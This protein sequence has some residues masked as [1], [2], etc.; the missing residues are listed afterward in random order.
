MWILFFL[1]TM[2]KMEGASLQSMLRLGKPTDLYYYSDAD[3]KKQSIPTDQN[4]QFFL[5]LASLT[6][7]QSQFVFSPNQGLAHI[8]FG[9]KLPEQGVNSADY[10]NLALENSWL[11]S[12]IEKFSYRI[13]G[14]VQYFLTGAQIRIINL[15][16]A[17]NPTSKQDLFNLGG[18]SLSALAD[19]A[20]DNLYAYCYL[21][22]PF[23]S[24]NA[25]VQR[26][27]P[28]PTELLNSSVILTLNLRPLSQIFSSSAAGGSLAGVPTALSDGYVQ[29]QQI[30]AQQSSDLM[31]KTSDRSK[32]YSY[33]ASAWYNQELEIPI[34]AQSGSQEINLVGFQ[35]GQLR[36]I[37]MW[38]TANEDTAP[39]TT[40]P[41][42]RQNTVFALPRDVQLI[43]NGN[44][45]QV[46]QGTS[47][48][49]WGLLD[50]DVPPYVDTVALT[51]GAGS[52]SE[53]AVRAH[54]VVF[55]MGQLEEANPSLF[56]NGRYIN[57][58]IMNARLTTPDPTKAYTLHVMY[59][60]NCVLG[61]S[62]GDCSVLF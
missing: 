1:P 51:A 62:G 59:Q 56:V 48:V 38:L 31:T 52:F 20:G 2:Y 23:N 17:S 4:T 33:P 5:S 53:A 21:P 27:K 43:F 45:L 11:Y 3:L 19:F 14:S 58:A 32:M 18:A 60:Y 49:M 46:Y 16:M 35:A 41:F 34:P 39:V 57:N 24:P 30:M 29:F 44:P 22:T 13:S 9:A 42:V 50:S 15:M 40:A 36:N 26:A 10:T 55:P 28:L 37:I 25:G 61:I 7:G 47:S 54:W 8:I 6:S 12:L